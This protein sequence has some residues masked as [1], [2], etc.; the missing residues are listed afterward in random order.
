MEKGKG[1]SRWQAAQSRDE[2][3]GGVVGR[4]AGHY[5]ERGWPATPNRTTGLVVEGGQAVRLRA[6]LEAP[7]LP[8]IEVTN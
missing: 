1:R 3:F 4:A 7:R 6:I 2:T 5:S 8:T